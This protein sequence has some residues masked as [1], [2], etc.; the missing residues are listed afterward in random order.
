[1]TLLHPGHENHSIH[2]P[3]WWRVAAQVSMRTYGSEDRPPAGFSLL[4]PGISRVTSYLD[5]AGEGQHSAMAA[6]PDITTLSVAAACCASL[7]SGQPGGIG[8]H[9]NVDGL[10]A[11]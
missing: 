10:R 3:S 11:G 2:L 4:L 5:W 9:H 7:D 1:M 6:A 8:N